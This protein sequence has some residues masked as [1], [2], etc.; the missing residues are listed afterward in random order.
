MPK[1]SVGNMCGQTVLLFCSK[2]VR[3]LTM[4]FSAVHLYIIEHIFCHLH[5]SYFPLKVDLHE[6]SLYLLLEKTASRQ[7]IMENLL[8]GLRAKFLPHS[9][10]DSPVTWQ[11]KEESRWQLELIKKKNFCKSVSWFAWGFPD[12]GPE[13]KPSICLSSTEERVQRISVNRWTE[14]YL[15]FQICHSVYQE[16]PR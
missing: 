11:G 1:A 12:A 13:T 14:F 2:S 9:L 7:L 6:C 16:D 3:P 10:H 4:F 8:L 15:A 5:P